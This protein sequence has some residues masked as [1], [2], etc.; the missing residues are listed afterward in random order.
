[1]NSAKSYSIPKRLIWEAYKQVRA[2]RGSAG[3][4]RETVE[5]F[6]RAMRKNLYRVWNRMSSGSYF[7]SAVRVVEIPKADGKKR[8]L[9]I[10]T[11]SDRVAQTACKMVL[12]KELEPLFHEDSYGYR[13][14]KSAIEAVGKARAR[15]WR[16]R[17]VLDVDIKG[18]FDT[19]DHDL[20]MKAVRKHAKEPWVVLYVERWLKVAAEMPDGRQ[21]ERRMG[22]PQGGVISPLL[23]NLYLHYAFDIWMR[24]TNPNVVF[25]RYADDIIIH[26]ESIEQAEALR[27]AMAKRLREC[28]LELHP[29]KTKVVYCDNGQN[30]GTQEPGEFDFLGYTFRSRVVRTKD[31]RMRTGFLPAVSDKASKAIRREIRGWHIPNRTT[32]TLESIAVYVNTRLSGWFNYYGKFYKSRLYPTFETMNVILARW[33]MKKYRK[34]RGRPTRAFHWMGQLARRQPR[35]FYHWQI[36]LLPTTES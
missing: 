8:K 9:G 11:V 33:A 17:W 36:G 12:E 31:G 10:P 7:P 30:N 25:E 34:L 2:N 19:I 16:Y 20:M 1:M 26:C 4:D 18:F 24:R 3:I 32:Q 21:E 6:E 5:D 14:G 35:L 23:A 15:C 13:P 27:A 28:R 29:E 22:T